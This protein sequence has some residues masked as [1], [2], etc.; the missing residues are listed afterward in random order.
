MKIE[1]VFDKFGVGKKDTVIDANGVCMASIQGLYSLFQQQAAS[2][3]KQQEQQAK[4]ATQIE[5]LQNLLNQF[6]RPPL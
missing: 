3:K 6:P 2:L 4:Q 1:S 5:R